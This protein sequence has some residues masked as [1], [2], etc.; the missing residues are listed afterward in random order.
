MDKMKVGFIGLGDQGRPMAEMIFKAGYSLYLWARRPASLEPFAESAAIT[1]ASPKELG[2]I[3]DL[4]GVCVMNDDDVREVVLG[5]GDGVLYGMSPGNIIAIH[6]TVM[7]DTIV[8][9]DKLARERGVDIIDAPVSGGGDGA[10]TRS[11]TVMGG[12]DAAAF[13]RAKPVFDTYGNPVE[14][15]GPAGAGQLLKLLNNNLVQ[16]NVALAMHALDIA[17]ALKMDRQATG[18]ILQVSSGNSRGLDIAMNVFEAGKEAS[19]VPPVMIEKDHDHFMDVLRDLGIEPTY[20]EDVAG[21]G[22]RMM[23]EKLKAAGRE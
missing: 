11:L 10:Y 19:F 5:D 2:E 8:E 17:E 21:E 20:L 9:L 14:L 22:V 3:C 15:L 7:P 13:A 1:V 12:G 18:K 6:S 4:V 23:V 16:A